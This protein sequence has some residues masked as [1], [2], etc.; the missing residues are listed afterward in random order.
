MVSNQ[1]HL[2]TGHVCVHTRAR[3]CVFVCTCVVVSIKSFP[4]EG[5]VAYTINY[6]QRLCKI[7]T[8]TKKIGLESC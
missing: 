4:G 6:V 1:C 7:I 5:M 2:H 8:T 3:M